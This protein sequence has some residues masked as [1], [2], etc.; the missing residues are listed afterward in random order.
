MFDRIQNLPGLNLCSDPWYEA[1]DVVMLKIY[2]TR[3][4][5]TN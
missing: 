5:V 3:V 4:D 1:K 2:L